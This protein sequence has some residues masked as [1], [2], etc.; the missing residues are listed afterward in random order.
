MRPDSGE[1]RFDEMV[2]EGVIALADAHNL[3]L[4]T[5]ERVVANVALVYLATT[6][7]YFRI[8]CLVVGLCV[9]RQIEPALYAKARSGTLTWEEVAEFLRL[10]AWGIDAVV[11]RCALPPP[12]AVNV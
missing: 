5:L 2:Q 7:R 10:Q 8:A 9:M 11:T 12:T 1:Q 4:R 6:K 3:S